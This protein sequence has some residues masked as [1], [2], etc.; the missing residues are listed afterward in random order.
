MLEKHDVW[1][2]IENVFWILVP[3]TIWVSISSQSVL[4][5]VFKMT[6]NFFF[7]IQF[8][9]PAFPDGESIV[10]FQT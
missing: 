8:T 5:A 6:P 9:F 10:T 1:N 3:H 7:L 2:A 4:G